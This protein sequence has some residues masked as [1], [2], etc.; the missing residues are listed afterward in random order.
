MSDDSRQTQPEAAGRGLSHWLSHFLDR[1]G[2]RGGGTIRE[3]I[4]DALAQGSGQLA[5]LSAQERAML[6]NVLSLRERRVGDVMIPRA[7]IIAVPADATLDEVL[8][9]F[10][11]A[12]HSRLPVFDDSLDDPRGM[13]HIRDFLEFIAGQAKAEP[14]AGLSEPAF[15][16]LAAVDLTRTL[17]DTKI[18]RPV[19]YVP[20]SMPAVDLLVRMQA[21]R[22]HIALVIDE[23]GGTDGLVTIEDLIEI[24]VGD[25]EDEHDLEEAPTIA[26]DGEGR[27]TADARATL[28]E[29]KQATGIDLSDDPVAEDVDTLG[30]LIV[31]LAGHV[32]AKGEIVAGPGGLSFEILEAD[33]RRVKRLSIVQ[34]SPADEDGDRP[35]ETG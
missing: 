15:H 35:A 10:R 30:G 21:T 28:D 23:Y 26:P 3:E 32:P 22:T 11:T 16:D 6:S 2:L 24:V 19:L 34:R 31:T 4:T 14:T 1:L 33:Q 7:D 17:A 12:G 27:F 9:R 25:I 8:A 29:L 5:D 18:M 13:V 20:P